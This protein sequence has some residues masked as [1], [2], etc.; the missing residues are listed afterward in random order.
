MMKRCIRGM[1]FAGVIG[2]AIAFGCGMTVVHA[3]GSVGHCSV[4]ATANASAYDG[5]SAAAYGGS[6]SVDD[7]SAGDCVG[8]SQTFAIYQAG[9]ACVSAGI[10]SGV[11]T[12]T[13]F[14]VVTGTT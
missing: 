8:L 2:G 10:P 13:G 14:G 11:L 12:G 9:L 5:S 1:C 7:Y 4:S 3:D 6:M